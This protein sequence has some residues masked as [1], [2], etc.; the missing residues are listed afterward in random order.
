[1]G[2]EKGY[3]WNKDDYQIDKNG[4]IIPDTDQYKT[5]TENTLERY[6]AMVYGID[7]DKET[8]EQA[9]LDVKNSLMY[10]MNQERDVA[11][12]FGGYMI[13]EMKQEHQDLETIIT[14]DTC[15]SMDFDRYLELDTQIDLLEKALN[16][17]ADNQLKLALAS[18]FKD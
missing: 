9:I 3:N 2:Y 13:D 6:G 1:M 4:Y 15:N 10:D 17:L 8:Y 18:G 11:L 16:I 14:S 7:D 5:F 12:E